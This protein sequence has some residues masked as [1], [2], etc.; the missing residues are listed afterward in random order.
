M[1]RLIVIRCPC[2]MRT[3]VLVPWEERS[4]LMDSQTWFCFWCERGISSIVPGPPC[5]PLLHS[6]Q[7]EARCLL[8]F[9]G[10]GGSHCQS[11]PLPP[12][13]SPPPHSSTLRGVQVSPQTSSRGRLLY[14]RRQLSSPESLCSHGNIARCVSPCSREVLPGL[15]HPIFA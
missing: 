10:V 11:V 6:L 8:S 15:L 9:C 4:R 2:T 1:S 13:E 7:E 3:L 14:L 5:L 12:R